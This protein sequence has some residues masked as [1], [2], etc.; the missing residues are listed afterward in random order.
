MS[1]Y[2]LI[3]K[4]PFEALDDIEARETAKKAIADPM[5][6]IQQE[7][8]ETKL[9]VVYPNKPPVRITI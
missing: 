4:V 9:Q 7:K 1:S 2:Q 8:T 6:A 5:S 3:I